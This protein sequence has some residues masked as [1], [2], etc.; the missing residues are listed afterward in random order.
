VIDQIIHESG[1]IDVYVVSGEVPISKKVTKPKFPLFPHSPL[2]RYGV[3]LLLVALVT[4]LGLPLKK[5]LDPTNLVMVFLL[6]VVISAVYL[7]RGPAILASFVSVLAFDFFFVNPTFSFSVS[8]TQ[9]LLTF[10]GL[11]VVGLIISGSAALLRD[12]VDAIRRKERQ[13]QSLLILGRELTAALSL[14]QVLEI[15]NHT[16]TSL[17]S[18]A[19]VIL[20][21]KNG[22]L[23]IMKASPDFLVDEN[24]L[25]VAEWAFNHSL[26]AG[27]GTD[28]LPAAS[29]RFIPLLTANG[30]VG[31]IG[32][33]SNNAEGMLTSDQRMQLEGLANLTALAVERAMLAQAATQ[34]EMLRNTEKL[35]SALLNSISH[36]LRTPLASITGVLTSLSESE[37]TQQISHKLDSNT[38]IELLD[39]ATD[40]ARQLNRLVENL[41]NMT[42]LEAGSV[43]LNLEPCDL[44]DLIGTVLQQFTTRLK[45]HPLQLEIPDDLPLV[46]CDA[47]LIAQ[48][49]TNIL[50]NACK[51]SDP[52]ANITLGVVKKNPNIEFF[53]R[54]SGQGLNEEELSMIF[55]KFYR[56][57]HHKNT[58]GTGLGLSICKGIVEAHD[59]WIKAVNNPDQ[60]TTIRFSL[61]LNTQKEQTHE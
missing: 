58:T 34:S 55:A 15:S 31:V 17:V 5:I 14:D 54:D 30:P 16:C 42:R 56:G 6:S 10:L 33:K 50:D 59:G 26:S 46:T 25:A 57:S 38:R 37:K 60:G 44:Q 24:E 61:P 21:P 52:G 41:L 22:S 32:I 23:E 20:I 53:V 39:S 48:V 7:G 49:L 29:L 45:D 13:T 4:L 35:Q 2:W 51:Y 47:A 8:D 40:Q 19:S 36:E 1:S 3:S 28:T 43:Q 12:Q 11:L 9:Y 18:R 27:Q